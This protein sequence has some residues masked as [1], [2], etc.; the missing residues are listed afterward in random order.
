VGSPVIGREFPGGGV[1]P[2][3]RNPQR[4]LERDLSPAR[5][6]QNVSL[7]PF[8]DLPGIAKLCEESLHH[9]LDLGQDGLPLTPR[10]HA[11]LQRLRIPDANSVV[12][13]TG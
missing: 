5:G 1:D 8:D 6:Q 4:N 12:A 11:I 2:I 3:N 10:L 9:R 7:D 13:R